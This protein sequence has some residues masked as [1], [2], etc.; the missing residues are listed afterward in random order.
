MEETFMVNG[1]GVG[2][3][4]MAT[5][6]SKRRDAAAKNIG[7]K[8]MSMEFLP[9]KEAIPSFILQCIILQLEPSHTGNPS[10]RSPRPQVHHAPNTL[11]SQRKSCPLPIMVIANAH[12]FK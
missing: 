3:T 4:P 12:H 7:L 6:W 2:T 9:G 5:D 11:E 10:K 1:G 8:V